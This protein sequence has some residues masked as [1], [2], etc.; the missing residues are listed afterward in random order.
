MTSVRNLP[1][2][3]LFRQVETGRTAT[4]DSQKRAGVAGIFLDITAR[5]RLPAGMI[6]PPSPASYLDIVQACFS[7][8]GI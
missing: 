6:K 1:V 5:V 8:A 4:V 7:V 2:S 3:H